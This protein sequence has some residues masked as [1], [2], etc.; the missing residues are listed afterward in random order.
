[1]FNDIT[2]EK[3]D[4]AE[5]NLLLT[6]LH[7]IVFEISTDY[8]FTNVIVQDETTLF[9]PKKNII[10][11]H[12]TSIFS[13]DLSEEIIVVFKAAHDTGQKQEFEYKSPVP[14]DKRWFLAEIFYINDN[15][16]PRFVVSIHDISRR[17]RM[18]KSLF[19]EKERLQ[20]TLLSIGDGVISTIP[21]AVSR[22]SIRSP[23][24]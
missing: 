5:R 12:I 17:K 15:E 13:K 14:T 23:K 9:A 7:D 19:I 4:L 10:G 11:S 6:T 18:E 21:G 1:M 24:I 2:R 20:T 8:H 3:R 16:S 22:S